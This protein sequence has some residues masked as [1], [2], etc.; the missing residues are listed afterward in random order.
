MG[1]GE[2]P[3]EEREGDECGR[4]RQGVCG[5]TEAC[6]EGREDAALRV[7]RPHEQCGGEQ[8]GAR[9]RSGAQ[10]GLAAWHGAH[11][12][13]CPQHRVP[14]CV[15]NRRRRKGKGQ[16]KVAKRAT[17][18]Q[19]VEGRGDGGKKNFV[20]WVLI[21]GCCWGIGKM[22][23]RKRDVLCA[24]VCVCIEISIMSTNR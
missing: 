23:K 19:L 8:C 10:C 2:C 20:K 13:Q 5:S 3:R 22:E 7:Q 16:V 6:E 18:S 17:V 24:C 21:S 4:E 1:H 15:G 14:V 11:V 12:T 9:I